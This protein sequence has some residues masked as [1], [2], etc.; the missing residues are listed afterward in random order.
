MCVKLFLFS[1]VGLSNDAT[2]SNLLFKMNT[3]LHLPAWLQYL[4]SQ[5]LV[6]GTPKSFLLLFLNKMQE[7]MFSFFFSFWELKNECCFISCW[8][9]VLILYSDF[10][11]NVCFL[12]KRN[13]MYLDF[14]EKSRPYPICS[15]WW[16]DEP[17][18]PYLLLSFHS[19]SPLLSPI[20]LTVTVGIHVHLFLQGFS[21]AQIGISQ[22]DTFLNSYW[23]SE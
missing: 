8:F 3:Q 5:P 1:Y 14:K 9:I 23:G 10:F 21:V 15:A 17:S 2:L 11:C 19:F 4:L 16:L 6:P 22:V 18:L 20:S 13:K 7:E 12:K